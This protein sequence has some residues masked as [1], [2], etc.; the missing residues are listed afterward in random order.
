MSPYRPITAVVLAA[1]EGTRMKS[2]TPKVLHPLCGRP[3]L[4][5]VVDALC[6]LPLERIVVVVGHGAER[7]TKTLQEQLATELPV[8]FVEQR[9]PRG[10]GE[11]VNV[12]LSASTFDDLDAEDDLIVVPGDTPLL[13]PETL[14]AL[15]TEHRVSDAAATVLTTRP[16]DPT[17]YGRVLRDKNGGVDRIVEHSDAT[18]EERA[19]DE[20]NTSI[21][22]F[23]RN[24]L[25]PALR[26]ISPENVQG[27]YYLT[28]AIEVLRRAGH[29]VHAV[30]ADPAEVVGVNDRA[31]LAEAEA[32]LRSRINTRW[33][34]EGVTMVDPDRTYVDATV[35]LEPDVRLLPGTILEGRTVIGGGSVVGPDA[36]VV[37][38]VV[39]ANSTIASSVVAESEI[40]D[41]CTVG[42]FANVR[43]GTRLATGAKVGA[44]VETKNAD[45]GEGTKLPHLSYV[46][47]ADVGPHANIGCGTITANYDGV[48]KH[49]TTIG[50][51]VHTGSNSVLVAPVTVGEGAT[52]AAGA[53]V[54]HDVPP[55][56]LA[57]GAPARF[58]DGHQ[59]PGARSDEDS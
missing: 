57:K 43:A 5:H 24:L 47:D 52:I 16:S 36:R 46:G 38:S 40:G 3:M 39:G 19:V 13:T 50:A 51:D 7:V 18:E 21:Y 25:A 27:E 8:E 31:Q 58:T 32:V 12:A 48:N 34:R 35:E 28:D 10:T 37:D 45:I 23:R 55:G 6:A 15:A 56:A 14:A 49:H 42:P 4:L 11:A 1:G 54:T 9:S 53:V 59:R 44:F 29:H 22:C 26:R 30:E 33:M 17:G 2:S 20:I 41:S